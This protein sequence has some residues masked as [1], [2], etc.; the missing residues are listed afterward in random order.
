M[1]NAFFCLLSVSKDFCILKKVYFNCPQKSKIARSL[2]IS[3]VS[4][5]LPTSVYLP[6]KMNAFSYLVCGKYLQHGWYSVKGVVME[7][8]VQSY[9][10]SVNQ[11][12]VTGD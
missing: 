4:D 9:I 3:L 2:D 11:D 12:K 7:M 5:C 8:P 6:C 1:L 10:T